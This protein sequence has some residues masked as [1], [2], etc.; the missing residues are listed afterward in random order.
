LSSVV[1]DH[2]GASS[3]VGAL[4]FVQLDQPGW[5]MGAVVERW[6]LG[7]ALAPVPCP[8]PC[9]PGLSLLFL[10]PESPHVGAPFPHDTPA[11]HREQ[12]CQRHARQVTRCQ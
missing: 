12:R 6:R 9:F 7:R 10:A 1:F 11:S 5:L 3:P 4:P 8:V 2:P